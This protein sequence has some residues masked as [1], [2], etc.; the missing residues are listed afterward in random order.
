MGEARRKAE[1]FGN[2]VPTSERLLGVAIACVSLFVAWDLVLADRMTIVEYRRH[3]WL[4]R[5]IDKDW[6]PEV[7][8][9]DGWPVFWAYLVLLLVALMALTFVFDHYDRR[10]NAAFY[11]K[12]RRAMLVI[13][14]L[15]VVFGSTAAMMQIAN[16]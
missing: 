2:R 14:C 9:L 12:L 3:R 5:L 10:F 8:V 16:R 11:A 13:T 15:V 4:Q 1:D 6:K 7:V